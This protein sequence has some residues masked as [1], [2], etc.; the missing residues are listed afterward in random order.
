VQDEDAAS[1]EGWC[2]DAEARINWSAHID[3]IHNLI[4]G[5]DPAPGAWTTVL[6]EKV[7]L[8]EARKHPV[9]RFGDVQ[10]KPGEIVGIA[11]ETITISVQGGTVEIAKVR[12][13]AGKK[14]SAAAFAKSLGLSTGDKLESHAAPDLAAASGQ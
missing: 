7:R 10:G 4:R 1:Y 13:E 5:C 6:G 12:T 3:M 14:M 2:R 9:R 8:F 11:E